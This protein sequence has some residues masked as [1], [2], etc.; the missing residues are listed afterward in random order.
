[1]RPLFLSLS[2]ATVP[3]I[4]VAQQA[5]EP[6]LQTDPASDYF[7]RARQ[8]YE[9]AQQAAEPRQKAELYRSALPLLEDYIRLYPQ[10]KFA[11]AARYFLA[12]SYYALGQLPQAKTNYNE[13]IRIHRTGRY[14]AAAAYR[15]AY[16]HYTSKN[17]HKAAFLFSVTAKNA[18]RPEDQLRSLYFQAQCYLL[19]KQPA[20]ALPLLSEVSGAGVKTPYRDQATMTI[21]QLHL[22]KKQYQEALT[23]FER[24]ITPEQPAEIK[25]EA[26]FHAGYAAAALKKNDIAKKHFT[27]PL[28]TENSLWQ[29]PAHVAMLG[30]LYQQKDYP[31]ILRRAQSSNFEL[32]PKQRAKQ[33]VIVGQAFFKMKDYA[34]A[35][36][37][38]IDVERSNPGSDQ[39]FEAGY[40]K[41]L[42][43]YNVDAGT[44][45][46]QVDNFI[47]NYAVGRGTSK[48]IHQAFL[49]KAEALYTAENF[50]DAALAYSAIDTKFIDE[51]NLPSLLYK[52]AWCLAEIGSHAG[53]ADS[54][55]QFILTAKK[56][57][58]RL[59]N[60]HAKRGQSYM[61]I[62]DRVKALR[63]FDEVIKSSPRSRISAMSLQSSAR[64]QREAKQYEDVIERLEKLLKQY[65][66]LAVNTLANSHYWA[67]WAHFKLDQFAAAVPHLEKARELDTD[68]YAKQV[69]MLLILS[70]YSLK[71][72]DGLKL[73]IRQAEEIEIG[74]QIPL[75]V[76]RWIGSQCYNAGD[77][78]E[79]SNYL[80]K[81]C[82]K[83]VPQKTPTIIWRLLA[84]S[85]LS[86]HYYQSALE[87]I[88]NLIA[89]EDEA[90]RI[91]DALLDKANILIGLDDYENAK[92][93]ALSALDMRPAGR[94]KASLLLAMGDIAY[95]TKDFTAAS[96]HY[97]L[98]VEAYEDLNFHPQVLY[99]LIR[100]MEQSNKSAEAETYRK[101]LKEGYPQ[102]SPPKGF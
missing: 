96:E 43:L 1:M 81:G 55:S 14:V 21:G 16:D 33:G 6:A 50:R 17:Y 53:A 99:K 40:F 60:A 18:P 34:K 37:Y 39:A 98:L 69:S 38:F 35:I 95:K 65:P 47:Q 26:A 77:Y 41:L 52:R 78:K 94:T 10:H 74:P 9:S 8:L 56:D 83:G 88:N 87:S 100:A 27:I 90:P 97:V 7:S 48:F 68:A 63:D 12:E 51:R 57:D 71:D 24:L 73:A 42:C 82:E 64:I 72:V 29:A 44:L 86:A 13:I 19:L 15:L 91:A 80:L 62:G 76:Y 22:A 23:A 70:K 102:F 28:Q 101:L 79:A 92:T 84:K 46:E 58:T 25:A 20:K 31:A 3:L 89:M 66:S 93:A 75:P 2:L 4:S 36:D 11:E 85:Q 67:G 49:M 5:T 30:I 61:E 32:E 45:P 54:F 59:P